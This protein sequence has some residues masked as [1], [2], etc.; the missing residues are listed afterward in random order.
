MEPFSSGLTSLLLNDAQFL[1]GVAVEGKSGKFDSYFQAVLSEWK[2]DLKT[3]CSNSILY[4]W[5][6]V[7][8]GVQNSLTIFL[9]IEDATAYLND[10]SE[11]ITLPEDLESF[12]QDCYV[13]EFVGG[14]VVPLKITSFMSLSPVKPILSGVEDDSSH[15]EPTAALQKSFAHSLSTVG[16]TASDWL[17]ANI[18]IRFREWANKNT[19]YCPSCFI[20]SRLR[21][22]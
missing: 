20:V 10:S 6:I 12:N 17:K 5:H 7:D 21:V 9:S 13:F 3:A 4:T 16:Q 14:A 15:F 8:N 18:L 11:I 2:T 1:V 22:W 19:N